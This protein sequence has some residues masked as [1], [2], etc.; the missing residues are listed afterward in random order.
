LAP[1]PVEGSSTPILYGFAACAPAK[2]GVNVSAPAAREDKTKSRLLGLS[3][4]LRASH[5]LSVEFILSLLGIGWDWRS[6][7]G[8]RFPKK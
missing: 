8:W 3:C 4:S 5:F 7:P 2:L 1:V 6:R